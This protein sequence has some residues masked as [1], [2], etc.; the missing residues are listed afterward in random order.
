[1]KLHLDKLIEDYRQG[2][3]LKTLQETY[4]IRA[5]DIIT[6]LFFDATKDSSTVPIN[7]LVVS[8]YIKG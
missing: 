4:N 8:K 6:I 1:M 2:L 5:T 7:R 3:S